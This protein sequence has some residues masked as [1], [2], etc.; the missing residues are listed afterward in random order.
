M[1]EAISED[2]KV[3]K[4]FDKDS[5]VEVEDRNG[6]EEDDLRDEDIADGFISDIFTGTKGTY[7]PRQLEIES[8][9]TDLDARLDQEDQHEDINQLLQNTAP[10]A[11]WRKGL[12]YILKECKSE[13]ST[14]KC[15]TFLHSNVT[16]GITATEKG[17]GETV[18]IGNNPDPKCLTCPDWMTVMEGLNFELTSPDSVRHIEHVDVTVGKKTETNALTGFCHLI[19]AMLDMTW[20]NL[21]LM[22]RIENSEGLFLNNTLA[23]LCSGY[24]IQECDR[25][26]IEDLDS[27][28]P[29]LMK[30]LGFRRTDKKS[31]L[32]WQRPDPDNQFQRLC[33][34]FHGLFRATDNMESIL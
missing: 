9:G 26:Q 34:T 1:A 17:F 22:S 18:Q 29:Y 28:Y 33:L 3:D 27:K 23:A 19:K 24:G 12:F 14:R 8:W 32:L 30:T 20:T 5:L 25:C 10:D 2:I 11:R 6:T 4:T 16:N 31:K 7:N 21:Q 15:L 13:A